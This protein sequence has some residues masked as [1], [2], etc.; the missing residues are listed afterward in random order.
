MPFA[1]GMPDG[2]YENFLTGF[3][4]RGTDRAEVWGRP[5][6]VT[7]APDGA[8]FVIDDTGGTI[9][10][11]TYD[12]ETDAAAEETGEGTPAKN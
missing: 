11:V 12:G 7:V 4:S 9:W 6:D 1:D 3:W 8:L 10:R 2:T 5:S